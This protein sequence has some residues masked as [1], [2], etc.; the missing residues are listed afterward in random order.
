MTRTHIDFKREKEGYG[1]DRA[2]DRYY[3]CCCYFLLLRAFLF[4]ITIPVSFYLIRLLYSLL[5]L[6]HFLVISI[7][8]IITNETTTITINNRN[9]ESQNVLVV[10]HLVIFI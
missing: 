2:A 7:K 3:Y 9:I 5:S 4:S 10:V 8:L 6:P 1:L